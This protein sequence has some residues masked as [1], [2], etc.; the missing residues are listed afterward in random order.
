MQKQAA[1]SVLRA[2]FDALLNERLPGGEGARAMENVKSQIPAAGRTQEELLVELNQMMAEAGSLMK[3]GDISSEAAKQMVRRWRS[4]TAAIQ[5]PPEA[6]REA[7]GAAFVDAL[8]SPEV[9]PTTLPFDPAALAFIKQVAKGM[10]DR[11][12]LN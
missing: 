10:K 11:G 2:K 3:S 4:L 5:R 1:M 7:V 12:E 8:A 9:A 6:V